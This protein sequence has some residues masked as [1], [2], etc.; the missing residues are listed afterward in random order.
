MLR[1]MHLAGHS[2]AKTHMRNAMNTSSM[3]AVPAS[4]VPTF[5]AGTFAHLASP[6]SL[7]PL[8]GRDRQR[9]STRAHDHRVSAAAT[10]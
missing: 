1:S 4:A 6:L 3:R 8:V 2:D 7:P 10:E 9:R 5:N